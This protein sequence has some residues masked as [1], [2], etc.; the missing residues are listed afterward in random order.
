V[1]QDHRTKK[2]LLAGFEEGPQETK[3]EKNDAEK[4]NA[5]DKENAAEGSVARANTSEPEV[6][7]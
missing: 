7:R 4:T 2:S 6:L 5:P 1:Q 3:R